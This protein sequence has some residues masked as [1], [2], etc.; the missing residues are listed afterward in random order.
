M[1]LLASVASAVA[2]ATVAAEDWDPAPEAPE[3][4]EGLM[5]QWIGWAKW[6]AIGL[7]II[8]LIACG[9]MMMI[10]RR[11]RSHL[12]AEGASGLLWVVGG[13]SVV[14]LAGGVVPLMLS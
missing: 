8:G 14:S 10:G 4:L 3:G 2:D 7:G 6:L 12:A 5:P 11:N 13:I 1:E 9:I